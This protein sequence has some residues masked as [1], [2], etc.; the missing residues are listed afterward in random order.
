MTSNPSSQADATHPL[1]WVRER[2]PLMASIELDLAH[3]RPLASHRIGICLHLEPKTGRLIELLVSAGAEVVATGNLGTT[4]DQTADYL[5]SLGNVTICGR[6][7]S[8]PI[9]H[10]ANLR[11][12][13]D[14]G[15]SLILDNGAELHDRLARLQESGEG[16]PASSTI[17]GAT[18]ETT[19]GANRLRAETSN[20]RTWPVVSVNDSE[21]KVVLENQ[22]GVGQTV[23]EA[24]MRSTNVMM[25]AKRVGVIGYGWCGSGIAHYFRAMGSSTAVADTDPMRRIRAGMD[26]HRTGS[27]SDVAA[28]ADILITATGVS[29]VIDS[30]VLAKLRDGTILANAG[31]DRTEIA[32]N[33]L[34]AQALQCTE[35]AADVCRYDLPDDRSVVLLADGNMVNLVVGKGD[36][37]ET[38]E[39]GLAL[40]ALC[41]AWL[42]DDSNLTGSEVTSPPADVIEPLLEAVASC[43]FDDIPGAS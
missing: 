7:T 38:V 16:S 30:H 24:V 31:H 9:V 11:A 28:W 34:K 25:N 19:T 2:M 4:N 3:R 41:L 18:E 17:V 39:I 21:L 43:Y 14:S 33:V 35:V 15:P 26:G 37:I 12:V 5:D 8:D 13:L 10:A 32:V 27:V 6:R 20:A 1:S 36:P 23:L 22:H 40:Q 29:D 42:A